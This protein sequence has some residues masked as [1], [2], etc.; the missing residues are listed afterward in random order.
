MKSSSPTYP[1]A[2]PSQGM[3]NAFPFTVPFLLAEITDMVLG[4]HPGPVDRDVSVAMEKP[5]WHGSTGWGPGLLP[6]GYSSIPRE[7]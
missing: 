1:Q 3:G 6:Y 2:C 5:G 7:C 4:S